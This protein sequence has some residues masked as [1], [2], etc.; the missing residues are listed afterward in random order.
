MC[1]SSRVGRVGLK[2]RG[3]S[4]RQGGGGPGRL[5][6]EGMGGGG[7]VSVTVAMESSRDTV[8]FSRKNAFCVY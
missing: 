2:N 1:F 5:I 6:L 3:N 7:A 8:D 4:G